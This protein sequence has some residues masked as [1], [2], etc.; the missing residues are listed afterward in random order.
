MTCSNSQILRLR[1]EIT[2]GI[3]IGVDKKL[4]ELLKESGGE[5]STWKNAD[6]T[7]T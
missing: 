2:A 3:P 1:I 5:L 6:G 4:Q 7:F